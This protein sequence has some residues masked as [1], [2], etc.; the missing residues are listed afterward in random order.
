LARS[1]PR[2]GCPCGLRKRRASAPSARSVRPKGFESDRS[3]ARAARELK[4]G[5][6]PSSRRASEARTAAAPS[7]AGLRNETSSLLLRAGPRLTPC[8]GRRLVP[9]G[10]WL[11]EIH[12]RRPGDGR[13]VLDCEVGLGTVAEHHRGQIDRKLPDRRV[14]LL[15]GLDVALARDRNAVLRAFE[16]RLQIAEVLVRLELRIILS[17]HQ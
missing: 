16:L 1:A 11:A 2:S 3:R 7:N 17:H 5:P 14:V 9:R 15:D 4:P 13:F 12:G 10:A 8:R 6:G